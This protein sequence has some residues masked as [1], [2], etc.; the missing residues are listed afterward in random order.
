MQ[1]QPNNDSIVP[2]V[3]L[4]INLIPSNETG[5]IARNQQDL[6]AQFRKLGLP[7]TWLVAEPSQVIA[8]GNGQLATTS[9]EIALTA[10][11]RSPQR[12][13]SELTSRQAEVTSVSGV[14]VTTI[15]GDSQQLRARTALLADLG[16]SAVL[17]DSASAEVGKPPRLLP[18]G[19]WQLNPTVP[20]PQQ[21]KKWSVLSTRRL[22]VEQ[23]LA[24]GSVSLPIVVEINLEKLA[25]RA[26]ADCQN[27]MQEIAAANRRK[28]LSVA[29][30]SEV[31]ARLASQN[32]VKPQRSI[33]RMA[34]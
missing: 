1:P 20:L 6:A 27:L 34:S 2:H 10:A 26:W 19:L 33:L 18:C 31:V 22:S 8:E 21:R 25:G 7:S 23:L 29:T 16:I 5:Q 24:R 11:E 30:I 15:V 13:R 28:L 3:A 4:V 14:P 12:L 17:S 32:E 9:R